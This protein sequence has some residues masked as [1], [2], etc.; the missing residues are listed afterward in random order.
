MQWVI[1]CEHRDHCSV[2]IADLDEYM[3]LNVSIIKFYS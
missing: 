3:H 2:N 1:V